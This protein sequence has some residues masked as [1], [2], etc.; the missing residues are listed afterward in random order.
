MANLSGTR[1]HLAPTLVIVPTLRERENIVSLQRVLASLSSRCDLL[2]VDDGS[3]DGT[4]E[5][6]MRSMAAGAAVSIIARPRRLGLGTAYTL[7]LA[8]GRR[9]GYR[10]IVQM[11][12]DFSH[13]PADVPRLIE[14]L[15]RQRPGGGIALHASQ[16]DTWLVVATSTSQCGGES[17]GASCGGARGQGCH[18]RLPL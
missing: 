17:I 14:A 13:D 10:N 8:Y 15:E 9:C 2:V 11:D 18:R 12:A 1:Q 7:A 4:H 6:L 16:H 5:A 3:D